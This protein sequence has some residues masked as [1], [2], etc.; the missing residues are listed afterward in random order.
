[1]SPEQ[2]H[3]LV[4]LGTREGAP[5]AGRSDTIGFQTL[6]DRSLD[7]AHTMKPFHAFGSV[8]VEL[9][10]SAINELPRFLR[11]EGL[12]R[13]E[14]YLRVACAGAISDRS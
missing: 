1:M 6:I 10:G 5:L 14:I 13:I 12:G 11:R 4:D 7:Q 8:L 2:L 9:T 3:P